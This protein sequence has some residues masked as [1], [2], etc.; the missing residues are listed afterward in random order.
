MSTGINKQIRLS[1]AD[2]N[3]VMVAERQLQDLL[4]QFPKFE[5]CGIQCEELRALIQQ[6]LSQ[7]QALLRNFG[8]PSG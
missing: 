5:Q 6:R 1:Q 3:A 7:A 4:T 8:P 2:Y